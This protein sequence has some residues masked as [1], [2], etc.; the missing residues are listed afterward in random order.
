[1]E[2]QRP[3][4]QPQGTETTSSTPPP[5]A[6]KH[7]PLSELLRIAGASLMV[8][9]LIYIWAFVAEYP[10]SG[11]GSTTVQALLQLYATHSS[12]FVLSYALF[13]IANSL[14]I[15][16]AFGI[17]FVA[18]V[19]NMSYAV[20]G[21]G[22]LVIGLVVTLSSSTTPALL[23]LSSGYAASPALDQQIF[24]SAALAVFSMDNPIIASAFIGVGVIF[25]SLA[26]VRNPHWKVLAYLG[27]VV[28]ALNII[29]ALPFLADEALITSAIFVAVSSVWIF[30]IGR[31][32]Y[33]E[34]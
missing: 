3:P 28:G 20:L 4:Q 15:V 11:T 2:E 32:V 13:T 23:M 33:M 30:G 24:V 14:S 1:M 7:R 25:V 22:T 29:R 16:G 21:V 5:P 6:I 17:Y 8:S 26:L 19:Q 31:R 34:G 18:R 9:A 12:F 10:V 27:L